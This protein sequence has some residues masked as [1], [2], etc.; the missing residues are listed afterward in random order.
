MF[1]L[2]IVVCGTWVAEQFQQWVRSSTSRRED[3]EGREEGEERE[4]GEAWEE[5]EEEA[6]ERHHNS[7]R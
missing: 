7:S 1:T 5:R 2:H 4:E 6:V 3:G